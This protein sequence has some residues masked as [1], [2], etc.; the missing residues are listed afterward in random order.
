M[1]EN[2]PPRLQGPGCIGAIEKVAASGEALGVDASASR[3][4]GP[5]KSRHLGR[6][7]GTADRDGAGMGD[8]HRRAALH[9]KP[10]RPRL[11]YSVTRCWPV[12]RPTAPGSHQ[13]GAT[14]HTVLTS[15]ETEAGLDTRCPAPFSGLAGSAV[16]HPGSG[17]APSPWPGGSGLL[18][19]ES[20]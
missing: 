10:G 2:P 3:E 14:L 18:N 4:Q 5:W 6:R 16:R 11:Q 1:P 19:R 7:D 8:G 13:R 12:D 20:S 9:S 17:P 15:G